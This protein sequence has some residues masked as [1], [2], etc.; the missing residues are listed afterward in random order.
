V[1]AHGLAHGCDGVVPLD[2]QRNQET[3]HS[4][5]D[6]PLLE[7]SDVPIFPPVPLTSTELATF[8]IGPARIS[9]DDDDY[10]EEANNDMEMEDDE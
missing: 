7:F 1:P 10:V 6:E 2:F 9:N 8:G 3:I 4:Q 5:R